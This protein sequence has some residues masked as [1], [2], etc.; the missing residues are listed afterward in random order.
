[1]GHSGTEEGRVG[2]TAVVVNGK[3]FVV[4]GRVSLERWGQGWTDGPSPPSTLTHACPE[5]GPG[6]SRS[7]MEGADKGWDGGV[8]IWL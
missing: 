1:M 6:R 2:T 7:R 4:K 3:K 5:A 8:A